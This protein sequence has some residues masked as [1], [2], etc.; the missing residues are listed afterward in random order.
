MACSTVHPYAI[1]AQAKGRHR[2]PGVAYLQG[3]NRS[4]I[5]T[6]DE[7]NRM[8]L[9]AVAGR[10][11]TAV[12]GRGAR[13]AYRKLRAEVDAMRRDGITPIPVS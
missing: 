13:A 12:R 4:R 5:F 2:S 1:R 6:T 11:R 8:G 7:V 9:E 10:K 3:V